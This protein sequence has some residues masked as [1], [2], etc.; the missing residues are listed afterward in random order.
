MI[1][2]IEPVSLGIDHQEGE[3]LDVPNLVF[4]IDAQF[5]DWIEATRT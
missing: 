2:R 3:I 5:C 1:V 4:G